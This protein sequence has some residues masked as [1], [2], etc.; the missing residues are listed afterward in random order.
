MDSE[1]LDYWSEWQ[2]YV[3]AII[4]IIPAIVA[5]VLIWKSKKAPLSVYDSWVSCWKYLN[6]IWILIYRALVVAIMTFLLCKTVINDGPSDFYFYTQWTFTLVLIYFVLATVASAHG[7]WTCLKTTTS[8]NEL[9]NGFLRRDLEGNESN[10]SSTESNK[11][12]DVSKLQKIH[13][14]RKEMVKTAG[15]GGYLLQIIYQISAGA[16]VLTDIVFWC[17]LVP[18]P[19]SDNFK[20]DLITGC[21]HSLNLVFLLLDTTLN[22]RP[23]PYW[24]G[25]VYFV[26]WSCLYIVFQWVLHACG[27]LTWWP[28]AFL[29]L[30]TPWA[31]LWYLAMA[32]VHI[33]CYSFYA[34]V[35]KAKNS[36]FTKIFP[37]AFVGSS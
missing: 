28:Y 27:V 33:P 37:N 36:A 21:M 1:R 25:L 3:C 34:L 10:Q 35:V 11:F 23:F 8:R 32:L 12:W 7:C 5:V 16:A 29:K 15:F 30:S 2:V 24:F 6:P 20:V 13:H 19:S 9:G 26:I 18:F 31:P 22:S 14:E 4:L 17:L